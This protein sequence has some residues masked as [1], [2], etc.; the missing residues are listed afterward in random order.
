MIKSKKLTK[1]KNLKHAFFNRTGGI[2]KKIYKSLNC[3][4]G[5]K[6]LLSNVKKNLQIVKKRISRSAKDIFLLHQIHSN[7]FVYID[8]DYKLKKKTKSRRYNY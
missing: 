4:P 8:K 2:S 3:G 7:K 5:S 1:I 6:D